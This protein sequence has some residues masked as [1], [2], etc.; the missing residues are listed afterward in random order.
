VVDDLGFIFGQMLKGILQLLE[1]VRDIAA[2][3]GRDIAV[4]E[5]KGSDSN[6]DAN[7][8]HLAQQSPRH[9]PSSPNENGLFRCI[10]L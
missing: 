3:I 8:Y 2:R 10:E 5:N 1:A 7:E 6:Q 9:L 4:F